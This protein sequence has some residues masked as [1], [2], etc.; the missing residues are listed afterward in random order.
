MS[1]SWLAEYEISSDKLDTLRMMSMN[2]YNLQI[3]TKLL[4]LWKQPKKPLFKSSIPIL[5]KDDLESIQ[6]NLCPHSPLLARVKSQYKPG[7]DVM[8]VT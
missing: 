7:M 2:I 1:G 3:P 8:K 4:S 6:D 5:L